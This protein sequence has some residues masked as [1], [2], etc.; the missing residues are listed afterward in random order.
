[1]RNHPEKSQEAYA[2]NPTT[3]PRSKIF[4]I[5]TAFAVL[6]SG[7]ASMVVG[8][9]ASVGVAA[10][11]ERG[12]KGKFEDAKVEAKILDLYLNA[13][14]KLTTKIGVEVYEGRVLLTG[15]TIDTRLADQ[16]VGMAWKVTG[17]KDVYNE[18]QL[19]RKSGASDYAQ[20]TWITAQMKTKLAFDSDVLAINYVVETVNGTVYLIGI[21]QD[22]QE[23]DRVI[24][25]ASGLKH[26]RK[27]VTHVRIKEKAP[28]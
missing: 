16:A 4:A 3:L 9:G 20:D 13:G 22:K 25:H 28:S 7:C 17:G 11:Q 23:L 24:D 26:V 5:L 15:A 27:V 1:M 10:V 14:L 19:K 6:L 8:A 2:M 12:I 18:I 21:A